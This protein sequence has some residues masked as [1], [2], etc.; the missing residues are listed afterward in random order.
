MV[1]GVSPSELDNEFAS[2]TVTFRGTTYTVHELSMTDYDKTVK[3]ATTEEDGIEKF[4]AVAHTRI[5]TAK[6]VKIDGKA[7]DVDELYSKGTRLV[8][9]LQRIVQKLHWDEEPESEEA[10]IEKGEASAEASASPSAT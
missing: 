7:V 2:E 4:D 1:R 10:T 6:C 8:R 9:Q 3:L 5:L